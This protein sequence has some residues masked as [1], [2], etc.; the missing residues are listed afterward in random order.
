MTGN[1]A[2]RILL[3][4]DDRDLL[5]LLKY[6]FEKEGFLVKTVSRTTRAIAE[7]K[8]FHRNLIVLDVVMPDGNGIDL[9]RKIRSESS[10]ENIHIF[11]LTAR[12]ESYFRNAALDIGADDFIEKMSGIRALTNKVTAVLKNS[13]IIKKSVSRLSAD[14]LVINISSRVVHLRNEVITLTKPESE[15]LFF[16][17]QNA[18]K[19]VSTQNLINIIWGSEIYIPDSA[20]QKYIRNLQQKVGSERIQRMDNDQYRFNHVTQ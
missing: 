15:I 13:F 7:I 19:I 2:L 6:N 18:N 10:M 8:K 5:D 12:S 16:L 1:N 11:F 14:G 4:D 17:M 3:V 20:V 9:C